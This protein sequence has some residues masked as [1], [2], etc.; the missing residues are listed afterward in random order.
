MMF[1]TA[2]LIL[3]IVGLDI[4]RQYERSSLVAIYR[5]I[6]LDNTLVDSRSLPAARLT[7]ASSRTTRSRNDARAHLKY[8]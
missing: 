7:E 6:A 8:P 4:V 3:I 1:S 5:A 2:P